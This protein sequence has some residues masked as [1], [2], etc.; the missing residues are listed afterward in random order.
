MPANIGFAGY[1]AMLGRFHQDGLQF[2]S[3]IRIMRAPPSASA[4]AAGGR[5]G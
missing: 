5:S 2:F 3:A 1:F 4:D